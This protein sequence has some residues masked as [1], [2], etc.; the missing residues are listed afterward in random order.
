MQLALA[1]PN[2]GHVFDWFKPGLQT[3]SGKEHGENVDRR[4]QQ[5]MTADGDGHG[6]DEHQVAEAQKES[7]E[8]LEPIRIRLCVVR[9][10]P[11]IP[12]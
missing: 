11:A 6:W 12:T 1:M 2:F 10:T 3:H 4:L 5:V 8:Q 7:R 9:A